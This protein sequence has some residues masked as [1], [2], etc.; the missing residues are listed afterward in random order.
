MRAFI[1][2]CPGYEGLTEDDVREWAI[3]RIVRYKVPKRVFIVDDF[4]MTP[5]MKVQKFKLREMAE[6]LVHGSVGEK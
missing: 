1:R 6:E 4:P 3:P 2:T 5:S